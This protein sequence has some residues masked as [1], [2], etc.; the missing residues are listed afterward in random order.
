MAGFR[1][2]RMSASYYLQF[3]DHPGA[4][5][6]GSVPL[7]LI[8]AFPVGS[9]MFDDLT[10]LLPGRNVVVH[11]PGFADSAV[12]E[13]PANLDDAADGLAA[14]LDRAG[15]ERAAIAGVSLGG[16]VALSFLERHKD[17]VSALGLLD[18]HMKADP[19]AK[20]E[21]R[22]KTALAVR[23]RGSGELS[24]GGLRSEERRVGKEWR[25]RRGEG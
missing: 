4:G 24:I 16:Y 8:H 25:H 10:A 7:V 20:R 14:A 2:P 22:A 13:G 18:T 3:E 6:D 15:I 23:E 11:L 12:P 19:P 1:R 17:R 5:D 21:D 9:R